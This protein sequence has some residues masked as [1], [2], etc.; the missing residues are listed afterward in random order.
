MKTLDS[1]LVKVKKQIDLIHVLDGAWKDSRFAAKYHIND[2]GYSKKCL[3]LYVRSAIEKKDIE[4]N[5]FGIIN[6]L[7]KSLPGRKFVSKIE[8]RV[9]AR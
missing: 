7:N 5:T 2:F 6:E 4:L 3:K 8:V 9:R 1:F